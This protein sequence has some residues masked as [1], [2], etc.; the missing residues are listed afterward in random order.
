MMDVEREGLK[1]LMKAPVVVIRKGMHA[2]TLATRWSKRMEWVIGGSVM[3]FDQQ[4]V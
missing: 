1:G 4:V 2:S 3:C